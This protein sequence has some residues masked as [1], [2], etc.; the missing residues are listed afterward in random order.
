[1]RSANAAIDHHRRAESILHR[2]CAR[3]RHIERA[4]NAER[5]AFKAL[6]DVAT[7]PAEVADVAKHVLASDRGR[8][9]TLCDYDEWVMR[10]LATAAR[11]G[12]AGAGNKTL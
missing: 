8:C 11:V 5:A 3:D 6:A 2:A 12:E 1:M 9:G 7:S 10:F 4:W